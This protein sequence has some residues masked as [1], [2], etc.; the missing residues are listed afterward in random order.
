MSEENVNNVT[1]PAENTEN[2]EPEAEG[3]NGKKKKQK[4]KK[5]LG[6]EILSWVLTILCALAAA[7]LIR[8]FV[9]EPVRVD[10][11]SMDDTLADKEIMLV[12]KYDY[13]STWL[14]MPWQS[15][16]ASQ[17]AARI[18]FGNPKLLDVVICRYPA[19][20]AVNFVKMLVLDGMIMH[21]D[22]ITVSVAL[23][24][25][26]AILFIV[27]FAKVVGSMLPIAAEKIGVDPAVMANPLIS[28]VTDTVSLLIYIY[29]A[30]LILHI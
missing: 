27:I 14:C 22:G 16:N 2:A 6:M 7:L 26:L 21:N 3:G 5:P 8:S 1:P 18:T 19:R 28:T 13:S 4:V 24:V 20:G 9:F 10:G 12:S 30:K 15:D 29:M 11:E 23:T 17:Q 25:S